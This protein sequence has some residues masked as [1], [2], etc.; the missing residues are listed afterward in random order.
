VYDFLNNQI[1]TSDDD[2]AADIHWVYVS[3]NRR[4]LFLYSYYIKIYFH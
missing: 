4:V 2:F 3:I 1:N